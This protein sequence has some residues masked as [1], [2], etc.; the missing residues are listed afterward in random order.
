MKNQIFLCFAIL[1]VALGASALDP[2]CETPLKQRYVA[3]NGSDANDG[4]L[5]H[6]WAT[7]SHAGS[8]VTPGT[9]V[10]VEDGTY[11]ENVV[12]TA[13]GS[14]EADR[15]IFRSRRRWGAHISGVDIANASTIYV[16]ASYVTIQD[17]D[18]TGWE[19]T[20]YGVKQQNPAHHI[21]VIGNNIHGFGKGATACVQG[22]GIGAVS[23]TVINGNRI[24][25][26]SI[27]PRGRLRC[28]HQ[29]GIY[30][31]GGGNGTI[32][33]NA[34]FQIW[35]GIGIHFNGPD[36]SH[37]LVANNTVFNVAYASEGS[38][39]AMYFNCDGGTCDF[40][41]WINNIF[42][43]CHR[44]C[45]F[46]EAVGAGQIGTHNIYDHNLTFNCGGVEWVQGHASN[47]LAE[48][49]K[50]LRY[51]GDA[52]GDYRLQT[53]SP[54]RGAGT[55]SRSPNSDIDGNPRC[56]D[57]CTIDLGAWQHRDNN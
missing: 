48:D 13:G 25:D 17:F 27:Y 36:T 11:P 22:G 1:C 6:P 9:V 35:E 39:G 46:E 54:G 23:Y 44:Y 30:V 15:V 16:A 3:M 21:N 40:N 53:V 38:G 34:I 24:W 57:D 29:H 32:T 31:L 41:V 14:S 47:N 42:A 2:Q 49:P 10:I 56:D 18:I 12:I 20:A 43:N 52:T 8:V 33:N 45:W 19:N 4:S 26:I 28:N 37:W 5:C 7:I 51:T 50:F 55:D